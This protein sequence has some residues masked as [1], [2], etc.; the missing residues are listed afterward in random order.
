MVECLRRSAEVG[1][2]AYYEHTMAMFLL[3]QA[4]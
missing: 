1:F 4:R 3:A 2:K